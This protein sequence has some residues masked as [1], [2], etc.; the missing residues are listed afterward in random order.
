M[1]NQAQ[2]FSYNHFNCGWFRSS[3]YFSCSYIMHFVASHYIV[4][5]DCLWT[6]QSFMHKSDLHWRQDHLSCMTRCIKSNYINSTN[7]HLNKLV[8]N[9]LAWK[10]LVSH[11]VSTLG[12]WWDYMQDWFLQVF[13][14]HFWVRT[15]ACALSCR[16]WFLDSLTL[17]CRRWW[18]VHSGKGMHETK[19]S[20]F[21]LICPQT[22]PIIVFWL[23][24]MLFGKL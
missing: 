8:L 10:N 17:S 5:L 16:T 4:A 2:L 6:L 15:F 13:S 1:H 22:I 21:A 9:P 11:L 18:Q 14:Q 23:V 24:Y 7:F 12:C 3:P 19:S 20:I